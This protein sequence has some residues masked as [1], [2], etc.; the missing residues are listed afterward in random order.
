VSGAQPR[1]DE[2]GRE[3]CTHY[4]ADGTNGYGIRAAS[5]KLEACAAC[6]AHHAAL[7]TSEEHTIMKFA[8]PP[9]PYREPLTAMIRAAATSASSFEN[10]WREDRLRELESMRASLDEDA[11][12]MPRLTSA[13][14]SEWK[15]PNGYQLA[16]DAMK[17]ER[18]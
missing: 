1:I 8:Q 13:Q 10:R 15:A 14:L 16:L 6:R 12:P 9:D 4:N 3:C 18:R 11:R 7:R 17:K 5:G 2:H